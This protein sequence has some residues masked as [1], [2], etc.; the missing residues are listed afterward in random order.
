MAIEPG[1]G[2]IGQA[3]LTHGTLEARVKEDA[4]DFYEKVLRLRCVNTSKV[5][6]LIAGGGDVSVVCVQVGSAGHP[7]GEENRWIVMVDDEQ[8]VADIHAAASKS[9]G[10]AELRPITSNNG[11]SSFIVQD[12]DSNWW[13]VVNRTVD[14]YQDIF[15]RGDVIAA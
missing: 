1:T 3:V 5:S 2:I 13:Q 15:E 10:V 7:Q 4:R 12:G 11:E 8:A 6:Q 9:D 14:Y